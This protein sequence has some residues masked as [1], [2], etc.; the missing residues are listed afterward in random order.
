MP[1]RAPH[2]DLAT[3]TGRAQIPAAV[4]AKG[5]M[6]QLNWV[7]SLERV[8]EFVGALATEELYLLMSDIGAQD[9]YHLMEYAT[10]E[11]L[12]GLV[13]LDVWVGERVELPRWITWVDRALEVGYETALR[14]IRATEPEL[15]ELLVTKDVQVHPNDLDLD[16]VPDELAAFQTPDGAFWVTLPRGHELEARLPELMKL[17][18][19]ADGG[20]MRD[21]FQASRFELPS[22]LEET[23][24]HF[25]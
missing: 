5:G 8:E 10:D 25:R 4:R 19:A 24:R 12:G 20:V 21:I 11:Q 18:W 15:I 17:L 7:L 16:E 13:D 9:A 1:T 22:P 14:F 23:L 3:L 2:Q 6:A